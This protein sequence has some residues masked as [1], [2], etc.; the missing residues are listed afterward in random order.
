MKEQGSGG[1][2]LPSGSS[3]SVCPC[4][5]V[6]PVRTY[7]PARRAWPA[8]SLELSH[9]SNGELGRGLALPREWPLLPGGPSCSPEGAAGSGSG[10]AV[11]GAHLAAAPSAAAA[12]AEVALA[13][14]LW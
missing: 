6:S 7:C 14:S 10:R 4:G 11:G 1:R 3:L 8:V 12:A 5:S 13:K 2:V 9:S